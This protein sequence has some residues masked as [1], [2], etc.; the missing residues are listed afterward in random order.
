MLTIRRGVPWIRGIWKHRVVDAPVPSTIK[1]FDHTPLG[2]G[3]AIQLRC[4]VPMRFGPLLCGENGDCFVVSR[5]V[6]ILD[7]SAIQMESR[8]PG[9]A[10]E[11]AVTRIG[12]R[13]LYLASLLSKK[14][15]PCKH[16][17][18]STDKTLLGT[19]CIAAAGIGTA[20]TNRDLD[21]LLMIF[22]TAKDKG[23]RWAALVACYR[24]APVERNQFVMVRSNHCC[25]P[26]AIDQA[27]ADATVRKLIL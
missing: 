8:I 23:A 9:A 13:Q 2:P 5:K 15:D 18:S 6:Y 27:Q 24:A 20:V 17:D 7:A 10:E 14:T 11:L 12:Y 19:G 26:C 25:L 1:H 22:L 21:E 4:L 3:N 16:G